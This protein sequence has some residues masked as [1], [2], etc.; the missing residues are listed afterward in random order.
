MNA[1][2][3]CI[4]IDVSKHTLEWAVHDQPRTQRCACDAEALDTLVR[5]LRTLTPR[6][7]VLEATG[8]YERPVVQALHAADLPV[9]VINPRQARDYAR[10][11]GILAKNDRLDAQVLARFAH[12]VQPKP[13]EKPDENQQK[14]ADLVARRRQLIQMRTAELNRLQQTAEAAVARSIGQV[15]ELLE[16]QI[17][18]LDEQLEQAMQAD[19]Q[20]RTQAHRLQSVVGIGPVT[21]HTLVNE[22]P[23]LGRC[24]RRQIAALVG[25]APFNRDSGMMRGRR[26]IRGGR[27]SVRTALYMAT[28]TARRY[29]PVIRAYFDHLTARGKAFKVAIT[30]CMRKLLTHLNNLLA[31][32]EQSTRTG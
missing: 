24:S 6:L 29:N 23:E 8:G 31:Q 32:P 15:I 22:L 1:S 13:S 21:A 30:A 11:L 9:A 4:G 2:Y 5:K 10:A 28:L 3:P 14:R 17:A 20:A 18:E 26:T 25:V 16:Q 27:A 19:D 7:V 12:D